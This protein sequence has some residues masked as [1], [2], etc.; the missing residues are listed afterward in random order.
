LTKTDVQEIKEQGEDIVRNAA[1]EVSLNMGPTLSPSIKNETMGLQPIFASH[2]LI[3]GQGNIKVLV[4]ITRF[5]IPILRCF[6]K[7]IL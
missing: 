4:I 5:K 1:Q 6:S 7:K 3:G 2:G